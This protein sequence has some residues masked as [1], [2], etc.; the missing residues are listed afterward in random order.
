M[1][2]LADK[3]EI[4]VVDDQH[5]CPTWS[6]DLAGAI[7]KILREKMPYGIYHTCGGGRTT[8][9]GFAKEIF[10][11]SGL[12]VNLKPCK[13]E[14]FPRDAKRPENSVMQ[15]SGLLRDWK[16]ALK[17]YLYLRD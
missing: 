3:P 9:Y 6:V 15:N 7:A 4:K 10:K 14:D 11:Q 1:L 13:T 16:K 8:W 17:D 12:I 2:N 5:G